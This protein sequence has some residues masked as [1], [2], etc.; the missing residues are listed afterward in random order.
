M[1]FLGFLAPTFLRGLFRRETSLEVVVV[2]ASSSFLTCTV[3]CTVVFCLL[4]LLEVAVDDDVTMFV[5][6]G[7][8]CSE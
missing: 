3:L 1:L 4:A 2:Y 6:V 8:A 5:G 7:V